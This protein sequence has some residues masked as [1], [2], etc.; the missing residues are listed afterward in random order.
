MDFDITAL[1][2]DK[3][4]R[5]LSKAI[6]IGDESG[7]RRAVSLGEAA[8][9]YTDEKMLAARDKLDVLR[10]RTIHSRGQGGGASITFG[11]G[12]KEGVEPVAPIA[13]V[14]SAE[15]PK[16]ALR[17]ALKS[18][19]KAPLN[20]VPHPGEARKASQRP[21]R[22]IQGWLLTNLKTTDRFVPRFFVL[23]PGMLEI[24]F[25]D[26]Q[27]QLHEADKAPWAEEIEQGAERRVPLKTMDV[28]EDR[29]VYADI[30]MVKGGDVEA[31]YVRMQG[32]ADLSRGIMRITDSDGHVRY[33]AAIAPLHLPMMQTPADNPQT[34]TGG[35]DKEGSVHQDPS[36]LTP[37]EDWLDVLEGLLVHD[38]YLEALRT[39]KPA[40][41]CYRGPNPMNWIKSS[42]KTVPPHV[43]ADTS[44]QSM[45]LESNYLAEF[46]A[47]ITR[48]TCLKELWL[49]HNVISHIDPEP[50]VALT[51]LELLSMTCNDI[52]SVPTTLG[53][54]TSLTMLFIACN[55]LKEF[56][57]GTLGRLAHLVDLQLAHN[58]LVSLPEDLGS[59]PCLE[60]LHASN[61]RLEKLPEDCKGLTR[62][63]TL[64][65]QHNQLERF[66]E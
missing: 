61:N 65:I 46:P 31:R 49:G 60:T 22:T 11:E 37:I 64:H 58:D 44:M 48:L 10:R 13:S 25:T 3:A 15:K 28:K 20:L 26:D 17:S 32:G 34:N 35:L 52:T 21:T 12:T 51:A 54:C 30:K 38:K 63:R 42:L 14:P 18:S 5:A 62:L 41:L 55:K 19:S 39:A 50:L 2:Q 66:T 53:C 45:L 33:L 57:E 29:A 8:E 47:L 23:N 4:R 24:T 56:S 27:Y 36:L 6:E 43:V 16:T 7:L 9:I 1:L 59:M 40:Q